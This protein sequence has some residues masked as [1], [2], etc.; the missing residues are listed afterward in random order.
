[1]PTGLL[2]TLEGIDFSGKTTQAANLRRFFAEQKLDCLFVREPG[3]T[4]LSERI[5]RILL[6]RGE[7]EITPM[8]ELL[9][10]VAARAQ[11]AEE[12]IRPALKRGKV[13]LCDRFDDST[14]AYQAYGRGLDLSLVSAVNRAAVGQLRPDLT[15]LFD[16]PAAA[17]LAR[18]RKLSRRKDRLER[19]RVAFFERVRRGYLRIAK[20]ESGRI[21]VIDAALELQA[22]RAA[23][24]EIVRSFLAQRGLRTL[25]P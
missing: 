9:L 6:N 2:I 7:L 15:L 14:I 19:E 20:Q 16:L 13:V 23:M 22:V 25:H 1:M 17:A 11:L 5:R 24:F 12:L 8:A 3:G 10:Y 4:R 21:K 18:G